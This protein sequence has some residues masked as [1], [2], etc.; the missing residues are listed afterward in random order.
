MFKKKKCPRCKSKIKDSYSFCPSCGMNLSGKEDR[1]EWGM[2]G[3]NDFE[4]LVNEIKLP[5]GINMLFNSLMKGLD[6]Q[7]GELDKDRKKQQK[8][9]KGISISISTNPFAQQTNNPQNQT[10]KKDNQTNFSKQIS[11]EKLKKI[12]S[13]P[14]E[15]PQTTMKRLSNSILYEIKM[16]GVKSTD[17]IAINSHENSVEIK[18]LSKD[19][20]YFKIIP[21]GLP[22]IDY[23][24]EKGNLI[25]EFEAN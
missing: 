25:I 15:E 20:A 13:L 7:L 19:K 17:D 16:P 8:P 5:A 14:K 10:K 12:A 2:L 1:Q 11:N 21:F 4:N 22:I 6:K 9:T 24:L 23:N 18:A 3:K